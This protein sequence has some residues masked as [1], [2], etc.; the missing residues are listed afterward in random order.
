MSGEK[1]R[2]VTTA[3]HEMT[4]VEKVFEYV[5][6]HVERSRWIT[7]A[8]ESHIIKYSLEPSSRSQFSSP[9]L[10]LSSNYEPEVTDSKEI[11][12]AH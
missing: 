8:Y 2:E 11:L 7:R 4:N 9:P 5:S 1:R 12:L 6:D 10:N 3:S